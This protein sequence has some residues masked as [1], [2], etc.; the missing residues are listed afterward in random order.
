MTR[1]LWIVSMML[2]GCGG[3]DVGEKCDT[4]AST[5]ECVSDAICSA[6]SAGTV[7][8]KT[9]SVQTDCG[10]GETCNGIS[11]TNRKSCQVL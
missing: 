4:L 11:G 8:R 5:D 2:A 6:D 7:C 9:C 1:Y 10:S 3:S